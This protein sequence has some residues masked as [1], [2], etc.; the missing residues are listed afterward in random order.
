MKTINVQL[1]RIMSNPVGGIVGGVAGYYAAT[2][3]MRSQKMWITVS[4][5][6]VGVVV[7]SLVQANMKAKRSLPTS[8]T[9]TSGK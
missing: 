3:L 6:V 4:V 1:N 9:V 7:G 8:T 2:K 5:T